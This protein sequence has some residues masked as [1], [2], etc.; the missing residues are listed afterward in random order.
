MNVGQE[1]HSP[2]AA[3]DAGKHRS[4]EGKRNWVFALLVLLSA[5]MEVGLREAF[6][7]GSSEAPSLLLIGS[8]ALL[9]VVVGGAELRAGPNSSFGRLVS[10]V[11]LLLAVI[12]WGRI[13]WTGGLHV[14][15]LLLAVG[16]LAAW[17][18]KAVPWMT[19]S[20]VTTVAIAVFVFSQ[21]ILASW[22]AQDLQWPQSTEAASAGGAGPHTTVVVLLDELSATAAGPIADAMELSGH[23]VVNRIISP[24]GDATGKV[25]PSL[26][27][28]RSFKEAKPCG[29][30]TVCSGSDVL[31]VGRIQASRADMDVVGFYFPYCSIQGLR[32]CQVVAPASPYLNLWRWHCAVLW[33][34]DWLANLDGGATRLGCAERMGQIWATLGRDVESAIWLAPTWT[35]GGVLYAHVPW[36]HPPGEARGGSLDQ[37]YRDN[38]LKAAQLVGAIAQRLASNGKSFSLVVFSDHPLRSHWCTSM[39]Y[40]K[41]CLL[42]AALQD[43]NVPLLVTGNAPPATD[44]IKSNME[45]FTLIGPTP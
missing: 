37:H 11:A 7:S 23:P 12:V 39:L 35:R 43:E 10:R 6:Y 13:T 21:P 29:W 38:I 17:R 9:Y 3:S 32:S 31:D 45:V 28:G 15:W 36:P 20:R 1:K 34:S 14:L 19:L 44:H 2:A 42:N 4:T 25:V 22:R 5:G 33:R 41:S 30:H 8:L 24:S 16:G 40:P 18:L 26:F 27:T